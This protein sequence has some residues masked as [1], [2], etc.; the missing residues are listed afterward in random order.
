MEKENKALELKRI[1]KELK[2]SQKE[3]AEKIHVQPNTLSQYENGKRSMSVDM[4]EEILS[5][6]K[7]EMAKKTSVALNGVR[8]VDVKYFETSRGVAYTGSILIDE[9]VVG[10]VEHRGDGGMLHVI[11]A[12]KTMR[13]EFVKR[14]VSY[15]EETE[16]QV[17]TLGDTYKGESEAF[18]Q[19]HIDRQITET[20]AEALID[21][22]DFGKVLTEE[23]KMEFL[24]G[25]E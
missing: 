14:A 25:K 24:L 17:A 23:E 15:L 10:S 12:D 2:M 22:H 21:V 6:L 11:F 13:S 4:Y 5:I 16:A 8:I 1:R 9:E 7:T 19:H 3:L 20:F 18:V